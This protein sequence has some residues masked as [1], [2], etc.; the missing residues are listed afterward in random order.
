M[1]TTQSPSNASMKRTAATE[2]PQKRARKAA[3][4]S[5]P[6]ELPPVACIISGLH[7]GCKIAVARCLL[8]ELET[9]RVVAL[10]TDAESAKELLPAA[11][12]RQFASLSKS[13]GL[14]AKWLGGPSAASASLVAASLAGLDVLR[15]SFASLPAAVKQLSH[16]PFASFLSPN[17]VAI[18]QELAQPTQLATALAD[19]AR[20]VRQVTVVDGQTFLAD[21]EEGAKLPKKLTTAAPNENRKVSAAPA[22]DVFASDPHPNLSQT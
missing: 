5:R 13:A 9:S 19:S 8:Q 4:Q 17:V 12:V 20:T 16:A 6:P 3:A 2:A 21:W 11:K 14:L 10:A 7:A 18:S 1:P 15:A 22:G